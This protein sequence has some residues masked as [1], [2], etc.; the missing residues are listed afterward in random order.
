MQH[1]PG[2]LGLV[3]AGALAGLHL[4]HQQP[5]QLAEVHFLQALLVGRGVQHDPHAPGEGRV[6]DAGQAV[7]L[8]LQHQP[9][10]LAEVGQRLVDL[11][12]PDA[13]VGAAVEQYAV[14]TL[15]VH[16]YDGVALHAV[17]GAQVFGVHA[18]LVQQLPQEF[19]VRADAAG[20]VDLGPGP[21]Q[22]HRLVQPL[23]PGQH[24]PGI[25][26]QRLPGAHEIVHRIHIIHVQRSKVQ[27][28]HVASSGIMLRLA[29]FNIPFIILPAKYCLC[30]ALDKGKVTSDLPGERRYPTAF[31]RQRSCR[32]RGRWISV[33]TLAF[34]L[35]DG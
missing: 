25:G 33:K 22:R 34:L 8:V 6:H 16:L 21:G 11:A 14:F 20:V 18:L 7:D 26:L 32:F 1:V 4:V 13:P 28:L 23:A 27:Y 35:K 5:G 17:D 31:P 10:A 19:A 12:V 29:E 2:P 30:Q 15:F 9:V 24:L 3:A